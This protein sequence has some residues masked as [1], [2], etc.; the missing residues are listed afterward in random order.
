MN[1][2][3]NIAQSKLKKHCSII[4]AVARGKVHLTSDIGDCPQ[5][6]T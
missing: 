5:E 1:I 2:N 3:I 6:Y 4:A